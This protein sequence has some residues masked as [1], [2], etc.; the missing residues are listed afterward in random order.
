MA[1]IIRF[2]VPGHGVWIGSDV[3]RADQ[4]EEW[5]LEP[6]QLASGRNVRTFLS[7][8]ATAVELALKDSSALLIYSGGQ[9]RVDARSTMTEAGS[10]A[11]LAGEGNLHSQFAESADEEGTGA[12]TVSQF[13]R[14]TTEEFALDSYENLLFSIARFK[15]CV[16]PLPLI[17]QLHTDE[18]PCLQIHRS[19]SCKE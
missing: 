13:D 9:T 18:C 1:L 11:R 7:H 14:F 4:D 17:S 6:N 10:Y 2:Q 8:I 16:V 5:L 12:G 15:E 3:S 19:L